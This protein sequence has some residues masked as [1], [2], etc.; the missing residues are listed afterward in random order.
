MIHDVIVDP[1][2]QISDPNGKVM[3]MLRCDSRLFE[4]FGEIYF[5]IVNPGA[6]KA[7][8][9]HRSM[10][11]NLAVPFGNIKLV[12]YDNRSDSPSKGQFQEIRLGEDNYC[13]VKIPPKIWNGFQ[14][15]SR[16]ISII[17]NCATLPHDPGEIERLDTLDPAIPYSW[18]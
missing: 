6:I 7:W 14:G 5:S 13:L 12:L 3:H 9:L 17:A 2:R 18:K 16:N 8:K 4:T 10:T 11:L 15:T 1:L